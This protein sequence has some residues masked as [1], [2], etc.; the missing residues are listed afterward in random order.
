MAI[1]PLISTTLSCS[2]AKP[3][4]KNEGNVE[5]SA[6]AA[7]TSSGKNTKVPKGA[8]TG[9]G[10]EDEEEEDEETP[11]PA[12]KKPKTPDSSG[13]LTGETYF[14]TVLEPLFRSSC[15]QCHADPKNVAGIAGPL[16]IFSYSAMNAML[17]KGTG[18]DANPLIDKIQSKP[19]HP[20][21]GGDRCKG[22]IDVSPCK[23][24]AEWWKVTKGEGGSSS[25]GGGS[26]KVGRVIRVEPTGRVYGWA[27][28][29]KSPQD[30]IKVKVYVGGPKGQGMDAGTFDAFVNG[31]DD[32]TPGNHA[33]IAT[34][35]D[36]FRNGKPN[37]VFVYAIIGTEE[38]ALNTEPV[39]YT[40][41][42]PTAAGMA[43]YNNTIRGALGGCNGCHGAKVYESYYANL[44]NPAPNKGGTATNNEL[45]NK[46]GGLNGIGHAGG[47]SCGGNAGSG[48]C[49]Q[50]QTWWQMEFGTAP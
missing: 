24:V 13:A 27:V 41:W 12:T 17:L 42:A 46:V 11:K 45:I 23:E 10:D 6:G 16:T 40:A 47:N 28:D 39:A 7:G 44:F 32:G 50:L 30:Q 25:P 29:P 5:S 15:K 26:G 48:V 43:F 1:L 33:F 18:P 20:H 9:Q 34:L 22:S 19:T 2:S 31:E 49:A 37:T 36:Q 4:G 8:A 14:T 38:V 3:K 21:P 35:P